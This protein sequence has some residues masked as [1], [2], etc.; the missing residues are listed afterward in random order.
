M[1]YPLH[2]ISDEPDIQTGQKRRLHIHDE[3][4]SD[5]RAWRRAW[6]E[7]HGRFRRDA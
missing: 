7:R 4:I 6:F 1:L 3:Q 5:D 2:V